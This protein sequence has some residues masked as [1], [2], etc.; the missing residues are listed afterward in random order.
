MIQESLER[1]GMKNG[2]LHALGWQTLA[3]TIERQVNNIPLGFLQHQTDIGPLL[4]VLT[5]N[6]LKLN[7][8]SER[9]PSGLFT[10]PEQA[11]DL[12]TDI[13][14]KYRFWYEIWNTDYI[15]LIAQRQKWHHEEESLKEQ[16]IVY[17]KLKDSAI[18]AKWHIGK[19][20][21]LSMSRD[22]KVRKV[23]ISYKHDTEDGERQLSIVERP[24]RE[25]VKLMNIND[26]SLLEDIKAVQD[27]AK[28]ILDERKIV[29]ETEIDKLIDTQKIIDIIPKDDENEDIDPPKQ[30][31]KSSKR[32]TELE[33][34]KIDGWEEPTDKKRNRTPP[35]HNLASINNSAY[36]SRHASRLLFHMT[37][38]GYEA[39]V[40]RDEV[41]NK[42]VIEERDG[43]SFEGIADW[44]SL[45]FRVEKEKEDFDKNDEIFLI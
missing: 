28:K 43:T 21:F 16:D 27:V 38:I 14:D 31:K 11:Q 23:G 37:D 40:S 42:K 34:L 36:M 15:P 13:E 2:K 10:I 7:T 26:T 22:N 18:S 44:E 33:K 39:T 5:P 12:M 35:N 29:P 17:F 45:L 25:V 8:S 41:I 19:V 9:S 4:R 1:S 30:A 3:K 24:A 32:K 6:S 20:E